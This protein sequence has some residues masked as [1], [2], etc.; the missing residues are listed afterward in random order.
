MPDEQPPSWRLARERASDK[1][2]KDPNTKQPYR[3]WGFT[4]PTSTFARLGQDTHNYMT[5][6]EDS[7]KLGVIGT[8]IAIYPMSLNN[9][10]PWGE[11]LKLSIFGSSSVGASARIEWGH[12]LCDM[13]LTLLFF[14]FIHR[15]QMRVSVTDKAGEINTRLTS[16]PRF[17]SQLPRSAMPAM[18]VVRLPSSKRS[19]K[20]D[21]EYE[22]NAGADA[23]AGAEA[24]RAKAALV[25]QKSFRGQAARK[26]VSM[27]GSRVSRGSRGSGSPGA[28]STAGSIYYG[29]TV[30]REKVT[31]G[32]VYPINNLD[33]AISSIP[34]YEY[35][36]PEIREFIIDIVLAELEEQGSCKPGL[37]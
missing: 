11:Q 6:L 27:R 3:W 15:H 36:D 33:N 21:V 12:V 10:G 2:L 28:N 8:L 34:I 35:E 7:I 30:I 29:N 20:V 1:L 5:L 4:A 22:Q 9:S 16:K 14:A 18:P 13:A 31:R 25:V 19:A 26:R 37:V 17:R 24:D 23:P 32:N